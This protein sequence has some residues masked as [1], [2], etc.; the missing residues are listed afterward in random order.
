MKTNNIFKVA[1]VQ[2]APEFLDKK[3]TVQKAC[4]LIAEAGSKDAK[5]VV[6]PEAFIPAYPDWVWVI[7]PFQG[8]ILNKL[9]N[10]L[11]ENSVTVPDESTKKLCAASKK[12]KVYTIMGMNER[13]SEKSNSSLF[14]TMLYISPDG[15]I[16]GK[17]RKLV[18][19][20]AERLVWGQGDGSDIAAYDTPLGKISGLI[21]WENYM[22]LARYAVYCQG[23]QIYAAPTWDQGEA[24]LAALKHIAR[25]GGMFVIGCCMQ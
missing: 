23:T 25:E 14:N 12:A 21:C 1:A 18:P 7:P 22:P 16:I 17:H 13:N 15:E 20:N 11:L 19:T 2:A 8:V 4:G 9:Y 5:L 3:A 6:F 10:E 24:W